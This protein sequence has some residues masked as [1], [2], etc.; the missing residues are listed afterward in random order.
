MD[1]VIQHLQ[2]IVYILAQILYGRA[3][4]NFYNYNLSS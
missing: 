1:L 3:N 4:V 2:V